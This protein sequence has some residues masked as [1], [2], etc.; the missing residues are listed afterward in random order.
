MANCTNCG[1]KLTG[2]FCSECGQKKF[3]PHDLTIGKFI[4][5]FFEDFFKYDTNIFKSLSDLLFRPGYLSNEYVKGRIASHVKPLKFF[6]FTCIVVF[7]I[8]KMFAQNDYSFALEDL[9]FMK[10]S[11]EKVTAE[12]GISKDIFIEKFNS[13]YFSKISFYYLIA[14][15]VFTL[16]LSIVF[17]RQKRKMAEHLVF[18][19]HFYTACL[20]FSLVDSFTDNILPFSYYVMFFVVPFIYLFFAV[21]HFYIKKFLPDFSFTILLYVV[22]FVITYYW[23]IITSQITITFF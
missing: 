21:K 4:L 14:I 22:Y 12:K 1:A 15:V 5:N 3:S 16:V 20:I 19:L 8:G 2:K 11:I 13:N 23:I 6:I 18:S 10:A 7:F 9:D 17:Y